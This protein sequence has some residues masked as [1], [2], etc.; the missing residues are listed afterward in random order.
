[1]RRAIPHSFAAGFLLATL[2]WAAAAAT[3]RSLSTSRQFVV[4]GADAGLRGAI[5]DVAERTKRNALSILQ[6][7]DAWETPIVVHAEFPQA[8]LPDLPPARLRFS[9]TGFGLKLQ[10][11]LRI[12]ADVTAPAVER[13]LLRAILLERMYRKQADTPAGTPYVN[14]PDWLLEGMHAAAA[15]PEISRLVEALKTHV[16]AG[17]I[18]PLDEF[19]RQKPELLESPSRT[20]Y[21]A[22][23]F[24]LLTSLREGSGGAAHLARFVADLPQASADP[25]VDLRAHFPSLGD[26]GDKAQKSWS[27]SVARIARRE[28]YRLAACE[29]TEQQLAHLRLKIS[30]PGKPDAAYTL[31]EFHDFIGFPGAKDALRHVGDELL[32]LSG[33]SHPLYQPVIGEYQKIVAT[34]VRG[35]LKRIAQRLAAARAAREL[36]SRRMTAID[37]YLNWFEATQSRSASGIFREYLKAA[38]MAMAREPR[39]RDPIS[40]YLDAMETQF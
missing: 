12:S 6:Q 30:Q 39:R 21:R 7:S 3:P 22:Y 31:E 1:M 8:D 5:C 10:L 19:L 27:E 9:Q 4:Y 2:N 16:G 40:V 35:K 38:E 17:R 18:V 32:V 37:D 15:E 25:V 36:L 23:A 26:T 24:A 29:E 33:R 20:V 34:L 28:R 11:E 13:E 14:P